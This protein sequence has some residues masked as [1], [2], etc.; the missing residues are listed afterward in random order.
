[1]GLF[2][3]YDVF[4]AS[5]L[6]SPR[7]GV[8]MGLGNP[9]PRFISEET[10]DSSSPVKAITCPG[11]IGASLQSSSRL[12]SKAILRSDYHYQYCI[13]LTQLGCLVSSASPSPGPSI[14][15]TWKPFSLLLSLMMLSISLGILTESLGLLGPS[16]WTQV[17]MSSFRLPRKTVF[18]MS[19]CI[20]S[21]Y[22][23]MM[24]LHSACVAVPRVEWHLR[25]A[26][27]AR[28]TFARSRPD[29]EGLNQLA[30]FPPHLAFCLSP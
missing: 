20:Q 24:T 2:N 12:H 9:I 30:T 6:A 19:N 10:C 5:S 27:F 22:C 17:Q 3:G 23:F 16:S 28:T 18:S 7:W 15:I 13:N 25:E 21:I 4:S 29:R 1:M 8:L 14:L 11:P 26:T